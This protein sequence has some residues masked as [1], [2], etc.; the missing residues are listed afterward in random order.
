MGDFK[1]SVIDIVKEAVK[2]ASA[3]SLYDAEN[4]ILVAA[5]LIIRSYTSD[6][7]EVISRSVRMG[8]NLWGAKVLA[9]AELK[10]RKTSLDELTK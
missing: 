2:E 1:K 4:K 10:R 5:A 3:G 6:E 8:G 7:L 9:D